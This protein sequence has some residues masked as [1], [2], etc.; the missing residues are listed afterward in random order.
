MPPWIARL[1][2]RTEYT[3]EDLSILA[4]EMLEACN[5]DPALRENILKNL[6]TIEP[7]SFNLDATGEIVARAKD[8]H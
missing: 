6:F 2:Q 4:S 5:G 7:F 3:V 8:V 1:H